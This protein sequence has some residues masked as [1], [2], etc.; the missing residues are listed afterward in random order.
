MIEKLNQDMDPESPKSY[1]SSLTPRCIL[2]LPTTLAL[3]KI[4]SPACF[5]GW[6]NSASF[7]DYLYS[8]FNK[9]HHSNC[10]WHN[11]MP[12]FFLSKN[13][14]WWILTTGH[15]RVCLSS[16]EKRTGSLKCLKSDPHQWGVL[17]HIEAV[18]IAWL[19]KF[20]SSTMKRYSSPREENQSYFKLVKQTPRCYWRRHIF[21]GACARLGT[22][23]QALCWVL[24]LNLLEAIKRMGWR[25]WM[26][27]LECSGALQPWKWSTQCKLGCLYESQEMTHDLPKTVF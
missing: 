19:L 12:F 5:L 10:S 14:R 9:Y 27:Y 11:T 21:P 3:E 4:L 23:Y 16:R 13:P 7:G 18:F 20:R 1:F 2:F 6:Q 17:F 8:S 24:G 15:L 22:L 25:A 26:K